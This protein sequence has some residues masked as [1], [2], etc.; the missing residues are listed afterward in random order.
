MPALTNIEIVACPVCKRQVS[1]DSEGLH[2]SSCNLEYPIR[3][4]IA[5]L[6]PPNVADRK[7]K[8]AE[9]EGWRKVFENRGWVAYPES[10]LGFPESR[11]DAYWNKVADSMP[12]IDKVLG[13][14][15]GKRGIDIAAGMGW[16]SARFAR[17]GASVLALDYNDTPYNGLGAAISVRDLG[18]HFDAICCDCEVL[19]VVSSSLDF[20]FICSALHH[21]THPETAL[22]ECHRV[23]KP[24][25]LLVDMC[26][27]FRTAFFNSK[28]EHGADFAEF[29][30]S[31]VN[32]QAYTQ[33]QYEALFKNA[34]FD[35]VTL[36]SRWDAPVQGLPSHKW[37]NSRTAQAI[38]HHH[39]LSKRLLLHC[40]LST[41]ARGLVRW[42]R[43][44]LSIADRVFVATRQA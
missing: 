5:Y 14:L 19:P 36:F 17:N 6:L 35:V 31:G 32:E 30:S 10:I 43:L 27:S 41:P 42:K 20:A 37:I 9:R 18:V 39:S 1:S 44:H 2:C 22:A 13:P 28:D 26:E 29:R 25:G 11:D 21:L 12:L 16:A 38:A 4:G 23:L 34:G 8:E 40:L 15:Q 3:S 33:K 24:G 7:T